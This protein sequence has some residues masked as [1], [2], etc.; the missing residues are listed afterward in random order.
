MGIP[1]SDQ[2][3]RRINQ[4]KQPIAEKDNARLMIFMEVSSP[5]YLLKTIHFW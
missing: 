5:E 4:I 2:R 1:K 3:L